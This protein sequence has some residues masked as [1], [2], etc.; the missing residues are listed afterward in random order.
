[1]AIFV[2]AT[3]VFLSSCTKTDKTPIPSV[4]DRAHTAVLYEDSITALVSDSGILRYRLVARQWYVYDRADTPYWDFPYGLRFERFDLD[5]NIDA[6]FQCQKAVYYNELKQWHI[7]G[8][9][10][11]QNLNGDRFYTEELF[12]DQEH[13]LISNDT[14]ITI[15]QKDKK[16]VGTGFRANQAFSN[17]T[18]LHPT[19]IFPIQDKDTI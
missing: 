11:A 16:I 7:Y 19:G 12:W 1:M 5:Y 14:L 3:T 4:T 8:D 17:Y 9:I 18:I 15:I 2:I 13:D 10:R 6:A